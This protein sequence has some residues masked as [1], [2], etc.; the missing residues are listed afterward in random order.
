MIALY[1]AKKNFIEFFRNIKSNVIV[2]VMPIIFFAIFGFIFTKSTDEIVF[3]ISYLPSD[4]PAYLQL[5]DTIKSIENDNGVKTFQLSEVSDKEKAKANIASGSS[6]LLMES[7]SPLGIIMYG[8]QRSPYFAAASGSITAMAGNVYGVDLSL[9]KSES[10]ALNSA[11]DLNA[12][13]LLVPGLI[14]Y[15]LLILI[16]YNAGLFTQ[17][18]EKKQ[19]LRYYLS[20]AK[21]SDIVAGFIISQTVLSLFQTALMFF[22]AQAFGFR[23]DAQLWEMLVIALPTNLFITGTGMMLGSFTK[24]SQSASNLGTIVSV[25][26]G[27]LSGSFIVGIET[28]MQVGEFMGRTFSLNQIFPST[29]A[30]QAFN[31]ILNYNR[32]L[33]DLTFELTA[34]TVV[35]I[36]ILIIGVYVYN[37]KHLLV[38]E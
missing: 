7:Q 36:I 1:I 8:D 27:F 30:T 13:D 29:F 6:S 15:G 28:I 38:I 4:E 19:I 10:I 20:K 33:S 21:A 5:L 31:Q 23:T 18:S 26:L 24:D 32:H 12:F 37:K 14:V 16:P 2:I 35:S 22:T 9:I 17:V 34:I 3:N 25:V 11:K